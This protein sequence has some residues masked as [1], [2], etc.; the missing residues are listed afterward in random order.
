MQMTF[1]V[2]HIFSLITFGIIFSGCTPNL[3]SSGLRGGNSTTNQ[4]ISSANVG[5][6]QGYILADNP[7]ALTGNAGLDPNTALNNLLTPAVISSTG[8]LMG[9]TPCTGTIPC[10]EVEASNLSISALQTPDGKW[11]YNSNTPEFLQVNSFYHLNKTVSLFYTNLQANLALSNS[12]A[13]SYPTYDSAIPQLA[14]TFSKTTLKTYADCASADNASFDYS[15]FILCF[16]YLT[17]NANMK[18]AQDSTMVYHEA[19]HYFQKLQLNFRNVD[20]AAPAN[21]APKV[22]MGNIFYSEAGSIGEGLSDFYS[23]YVNGRP[24][25]GEWAAGRILNASRPISESDPM[26]A[27]GISVDPSQRLSYP[28]F[29]DYDPNYPLAPIEDIHYAGMIISHYLVAL[30]EDFRTYCGMTKPA[31][32]NKVVHLMSETL[33]ELGDLTTV[34]T[35]AGSAGK[36]NFNTTGTNAKD[37][38]RLV[39]PITYRSFAQTFAKNLFQNMQQIPQC[40][41]ALYGQ[42][43]IETLLDDYGLL[44]FRTYNKNRNLSNPASPSLT[45]VSVSPTNRKKSALIS[46]SLI[47]LDPT[48][49]ANAAFIIDAQ[50]QIAAGVAQL[51]SAGAILATGTIDQSAGGFAYNNGNGRVSP[52]EVV[53]I[54]LNLYNDSNSTMGGIQV[55]ANDWN[56][57]DLATGKPYIFDQW[58]LAAEGGVAYVAPLTPPATENFAPV[59]LVQSTATNGSATQWITQNAYRQK[60]AVDPTMCLDP[61]NDKDCF[62][63]AIKGVDQA[64]YSKLNPKSNWGQT[65]MDPQ[66]K[67]AYPL[68]WSNVMLFQVSKHIPPGTV[69]NC[70]LRVRFT[71]CEDCYHDPKRKNTDL[72]TYDYVDRDYN[73]ADPFKVISLQFS[74]ID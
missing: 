53:A 14:Q 17:G 28:Q 51:Q 54:A 63:R 71:N 39:N 43:R 59:C 36:V 37:W 72:Q 13:F 52:G 26:H 57:V 22:D 41:G 58:P 47:K 11:A 38:Y 6:G 27:S 29:L 49:N 16:G 30:S 69:V 45:N 12:F 46:K 42:D 64:H 8:F 3:G 55:L 18:F 23:Y 5:A 20:P 21:P 32:S 74:I 62:I 7:I 34:G 2:S 50:N 68:G 10:F 24:H 60:V 61:A 44:L 35:N 66:T 31:A 25:F 65:M 9:N 40:N 73:G 48:T 33:A 56:H 15:N 70:R 4:N 1:K 19:G 67:A